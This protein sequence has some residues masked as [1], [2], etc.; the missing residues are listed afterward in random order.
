MFNAYLSVFTLL[1]N[2]FT[3]DCSCHTAEMK[4]VETI[5]SYTLLLF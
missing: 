2:I 3:T 4:V 1:L 5:W